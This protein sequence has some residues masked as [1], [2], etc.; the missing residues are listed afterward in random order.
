MHENDVCDMIFGL[1]MEFYFAQTHCKEMIVLFPELIVETSSLVKGQQKSIIGVLNLDFIDV[2][3]G[4]IP[5]TKEPVYEVCLDIVN[6]EILLSGFVKTELEYPC[7]RCL[8]SVLIKV[9]GSVEAHYINKEACSAKVEEEVVS[10][11]N[12]IYYEGSEIDLY[13]RIMEAVA[14]EVPE[15]VLCSPECKGLCSFCGE[16]LNE[17]PDHI[18][19]E[20]KST[21][22]FSP[23]SKLKDLNKI[24]DDK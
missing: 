13:D 16:N 4:K 1:E 23:F 24:F 18:C 19:G 12:V 3:L 20:S 14:L 6:E 2:P 21:V 7:V 11:E 15:Y 17:K 9:N 10:L 8:E 5:F 22:E